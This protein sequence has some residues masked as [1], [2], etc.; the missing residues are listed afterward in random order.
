MQKTLVSTWLFSF[1]KF[2]KNRFSHPTLLEL[3][4]LWSLL[5]HWWQFPSPPLLR[6]LYQWWLSSN[7]FHILLVKY[8]R[9]SS[10]KCQSNL[11]CML[12]PWPLPQ[13]VWQNNW[14][15]RNKWRRHW[16]G[17]VSSSVQPCLWCCK[18]KACLH[19]TLSLDHR[20]REDCLK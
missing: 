5:C 10:V 12:H 16:Q 13:P 6:W 3:L 11:N 4:I 1:H 19:L 8:W 18:M 20:I 9:S 7:I 2:L 17:S 14:L 15:N